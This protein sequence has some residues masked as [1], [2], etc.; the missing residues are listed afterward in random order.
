MTE[1]GQPPPARARVQRGRGLRIFL[2]C[3]GR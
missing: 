2:V 1:L 3:K